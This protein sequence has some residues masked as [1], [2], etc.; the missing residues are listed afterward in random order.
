MQSWFQ[1]AGRPE[2]DQQKTR[3]HESHDHIDDTHRGFI[4][5][6]SDVLQ[7]LT[8][9]DVLKPRCEHS[10]IYLQHGLLQHGAHR[11]ILAGV[12]DNT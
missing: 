12:A 10:I 4:A 9:S 2:L 6:C 3:V 8:S 11:E 7:E 5:I 1:P